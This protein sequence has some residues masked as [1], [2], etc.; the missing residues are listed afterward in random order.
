VI[1]ADEGRSKERD[2]VDESRREGEKESGQGR[3][4]E[5]TMPIRDKASAGKR[6]KREKGR[7]DE[8]GGGGVGTSKC[9]RSEP[10][11][12]VPVRKGT[13][14]EGESKKEQVVLVKRACP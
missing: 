6:L 1:F 10:T 14:D 2:A 5:R 9:Q 11:N 8:G 13:W 7:G 3:R 12:F 4:A